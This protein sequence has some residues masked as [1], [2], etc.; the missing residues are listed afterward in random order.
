MSTEQDLDFANRK[1]E[2]SV[3][4]QRADGGPA[5]RRCSDNDHAVPAEV[6]GPDIDAWMK[7]ARYVSCHRIDGAYTS[8]LAKRAG[9]TCEREV[10]R[11][12]L[13]AS[14]RRHDVVDVERGLLTELRKATVLTTVRRSRGRRPTQRC[15]DIRL[16]HERVSPQRLP[17][18]G[19]AMRGT[20]RA[21]RALRLRFVRADRGLRRGLDDRADRGDARPVLAAS[22]TCRLRRARSTGQE[23]YA[24]RHMT[25]PRP[26]SRGQRILRARSLP[27]CIPPWTD[28]VLAPRWIDVRSTTVNYRLRWPATRLAGQRTWPC[29]PASTRPQPVRGVA[30]S[31]HNVDRR[32]A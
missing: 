14:V 2:I 32:R 18:A 1:D 30:P 28:S 5:D 29:P 12:G 6:L 22:V 23:P 8:G 4:V 26:S 27:S 10:L 25:L 9:D 16:R 3:H 15:A 20:Q 17:R 21:R 7:Q 11:T 31:A 24:T 13:A 19:V